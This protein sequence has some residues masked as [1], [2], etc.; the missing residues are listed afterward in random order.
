[1]PSITFSRYWFLAIPIVALSVISYVLISSRAPA[2]ITAQ[3][4]RGDIMQEVLASGNVAS[5]KN[6]D[7]QFQNAGKITSLAVESGDTVTAGEV[8]ASLDT[9]VLSAE[10]DQ[11]LSALDAQ[12]AQL[13]SLQEG[14]RPEQIAVTEAQV[15]SDQTAQ[16]Q[17]EQGVIDAI[18]NAYT[19]SD[20]VVKNTV[21]LFVS[22]PQT[23]PQ[24]SFGVYSPQIKNTVE[25]DR[26]AMSLT[27]ATWQQSIAAL[28][29]QSDLTGAESLAQNNLQA[30]A[31]LLADANNALSQAATG[32]QITTAQVNAWMAGV[33]TARS[34]ISS[35]I[36]TLTAAITAQKNAAAALERD[37]K[38]LALQKAGSTSST[39]AAQEA[40]VEAAQAN[41]NALNAQLAQMR[42]VAPLTG[43][44]T[45]VN[46]EAGETVTPG[47]VAISMIPDSK[48][49]IDVN[50]SEDNVANV[51]IG[52]PARITLD[53]FG[54]NTEW[55]GTV[56]KID[57]AQTIIGGAV[58]YD[59]TVN[60]DQPDDRVKPGMT[61]NIWIQTGAA[62]STLV[63]PASALSND[64]SGTYVQLVDNGAVK[65]MPVTVGLKGE[66][67]SV[68]VLTGVQEGQE[69][70]I[71]TK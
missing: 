40:Q 21:D 2:Y 4:K 24:L 31:M 68:Q 12:K 16:L 60:F 15:A 42:I 59:T 52:D 43:I 44:V 26:S 41:V 10:R 36:S 45:K 33:A 17:A 37:Q 14:T 64:A 22:N 6:I 46:I 62:S 3:V 61:A 53:A 38:T 35:A 58:Y 49:Q 27:L 11:A 50:L 67:G 57:P 63:L 55:Q 47:D 34:S 29:A 23:N 56:V 25:S 18:K 39:I 54:N 8:L 5:P 65:K 70:I 20:S 48:L 9:S 13:A 30:T 28:V 7:L 51:Q 66:D 1:M 69:V 32:S 19:V 71:G